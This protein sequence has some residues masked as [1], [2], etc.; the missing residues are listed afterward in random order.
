MSDE[1][2]YPRVVR[3]N[4]ETMMPERKIP[5]PSQ[6]FCIINTRE[7]RVVWSGLTIL[8]VRKAALPEIVHHYAAFILPLARCEWL[9]K[10]SREKVGPMPCGGF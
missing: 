7:G 4:R 9:D 5:C 2:R 6:R 3:K 8:G 1:K 10:M